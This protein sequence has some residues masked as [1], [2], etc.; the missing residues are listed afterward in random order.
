MSTTVPTDDDVHS[1][2]ELLAPIGR[3]GAE[4][5]DSGFRAFLIST[6]RVGVRT[7]GPGITGDRY[8]P[9]RLKRI[10]FTDIA[11]SK[12]EWDGIRCSNPGISAKRRVRRYMK[13]NLPGECRSERDTELTRAFLDLATP[14]S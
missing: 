6:A 8:L 5:R 3:N 11:G 14:P 4:K 10:A 7:V 2:A 1:V 9:D 13:A 12:I